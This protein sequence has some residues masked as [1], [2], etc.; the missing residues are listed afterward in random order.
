ML[1]V[2]KVF[3]REP[4]PGGTILQVE[5]FSNRH[6]EQPSGSP[7]DTNPFGRHLDRAV[8]DFL[9]ATGAEPDVGEYDVTPDDD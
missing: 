1:R 9:A 7:D 8:V 2:R 6:E 3:C 4:G 5:R